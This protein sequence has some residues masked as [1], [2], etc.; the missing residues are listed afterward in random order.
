MV[1]EC[2]LSQPG[3]NCGIMQRIDAIPVDIDI[4]VGTASPET[5]YI[6]IA[7]IAQLNVSFSARCADGFYGRDC[8]TSCPDFESCAGCGLSVF[9]GE[10]CQF[11]TE[12]CS[13]VYCN[14]NGDCVD[15]SSAC[16]C[17]PG[18]TGDLCQNIDDC[19]G[20]SC[21]DSG[22]CIDQI[23]GFKCNCNPG[24]TGDLC[25]VNIDDCEGVSCNNSGECID[26]I[27]GF[28]CECDLGF[29]GTFCQHNIDDCEDMNCN[30]G[31]CVDEVNGFTCQCNPGFFGNACENTDYCFGITCSG[32]GQC[33]N[34]HDTFTCTCE[35]GYTGNQCQIESKYYYVQRKF[36][37][38]K[39]TTSCHCLQLL[40]QQQVC[41]LGM[42]N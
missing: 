8:L 17:N 2:S 41:I 15:G 1:V 34:L 4:T 9:T 28:V 33:E 23:D 13:E 5:T 42:C 35:T 7:G 32:N 31:G 10:F 11:S 30:D 38:Y 20:V 16:D 12:D 19:E 25:Q 18:F 24:F 37:R 39:T 40:E 29:T 14:G 6:G 36:S 21:N 3:M 26:Q 22:E 27:D